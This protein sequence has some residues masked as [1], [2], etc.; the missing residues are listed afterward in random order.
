MTV[1]SSHGTGRIFHLTT[2]ITAVLIV[3]SYSASLVS[4]VMMTKY[5]LP[6]NNFE[7]FLS[8]GTYQL[9][10]LAGSAHMS[11]FKVITSVQ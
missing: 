7:E 4:Y 8:D 10:V 2:F 6:F 9:G 11:Y 3:T 5:T 1:T